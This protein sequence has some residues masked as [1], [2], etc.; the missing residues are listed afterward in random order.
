MPILIPLMDKYHWDPVWF[1][2]MVTIMVAIGTITPP[3]AMNLYVGCRISNITIEEL[4]PPVIPLMIATMIGLV[5][6]TLFPGLTL[7]FPRMLGLIR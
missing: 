6:L 2:V 3:V 5:I 1:G 4:T 7:F